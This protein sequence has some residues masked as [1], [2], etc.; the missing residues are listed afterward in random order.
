MSRQPG[1]KHIDDVLDDIEL[2]L[3]L[4]EVVEEKQPEYEPEPRDAPFWEGGRK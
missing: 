4:R 1:F 2:L 3:E